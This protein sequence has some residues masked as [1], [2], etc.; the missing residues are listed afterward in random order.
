MKPFVKALVIHLA[1][2]IAY[3]L[4]LLLVSRNGEGLLIAF[5]VSIVQFMVGLILGIVQLATA[6]GNE[7]KRMAGLGNLLGGVLTIII[8]FASCFILL[9]GMSI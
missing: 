6:Q 8:G 5:W 2:F 4:L 7:Q 9:S 3:T 1:I